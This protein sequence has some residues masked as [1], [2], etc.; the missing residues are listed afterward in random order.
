V[1]DKSRGTTAR[2]V[3]AVRRATGLPAPHGDVQP[4]RMRRS[5][6]P[7]PF[8]FVLTV[9]AG[10][11]ALPELVLML[12][13]H[14]L[15]GSGRWRALAYQFGGF[16]AGLLQGWR[17]NFAA[18]PGTMFVTHAFLHAGLAHM[19]GNLGAFAAIAPPVLRRFGTRGFL[20]VYAVSVLGGGLA[21]G[22]LSSSTAPMVGASGAIFGLVGAW[23]WMQGADHA[24]RGTGA[25]TLRVL[26]IAAGL[27]LLNLAMWLLAGGVLAWETHLGGYLAGLGMAALLAPAP[28]PHAAA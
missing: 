23:T 18:Q 22:L 12:A 13:D 11:F 8:P 9:V 28:Q 20:G 3:R 2:L 5:A 10:L 7:V 15:T 1:N 24:Q 17:P 6:P 26:G 21:F 25:A 19:V 14:G 27:A 4:A 16:W